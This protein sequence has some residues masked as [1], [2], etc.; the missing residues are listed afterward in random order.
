MV[1]TPHHRRGLCY[2]FQTTC[3][4]SAGSMRSRGDRRKSE[5]YLPLEECGADAS[6]LNRRK[7]PFSPARDDSNHETPAGNLREG[8][9]EYLRAILTEVR[10]NPPTTGEDLTA[11]F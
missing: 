4:V 7:Y 10:R 8:E 11:R 9:E 2:V 6:G 3:S 1:E 5:S